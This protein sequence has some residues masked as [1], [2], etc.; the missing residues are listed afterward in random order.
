MSTYSAVLAALPD[1]RTTL[2]QSVQNESQN[3][4]TTTLFRGAFSAFT[5]PLTNVHATGIGIRL[6]RGQIVE[7]DFVLKVYV[8]DKLDL[9]TDTPAL[10]REF[11]GV[12][13]DVEQL[14][15]QTPLN[16]GINNPR[17]RRRPI[18][19]GLSIGLIDSFTAGT[20]GCFVRRS[21]GSILALTNS[22]VIAQTTSGTVRLGTAIN[23]PSPGESGDDGNIENSFATLKEFIPIKFPTNSNAII[24]NQFDAALAL[25]RDQSLITLGQILSIPNYQPLLKN[26]LPGMQVIK[27]ARTTRLTQGTI[28]AISVQG[29]IPNPLLKVEE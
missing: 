3:F 16:S 2:F 11:Q 22:H 5:T 10:M 20:L 4:S 24:L 26:A 8:Y 17:T 7:D 21:D 18:I 9:G 6:R 29:V 1:Y 23:Q 25:V 13:V 28:T 12:E 27:S 19:G 14:P 15:V